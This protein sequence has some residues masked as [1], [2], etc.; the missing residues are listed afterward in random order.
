MLLKCPECELPVSDKAFNCPH[1]GY[2]ISQPTNKSTKSSKRNS[3]KRKR[4][5][6]GFGQITEIK[7]KRLRKPFRASVTVGKTD[8]GRPICKLLKPDAYFETYNDAYAALLEY[9]RNP[10]DLDNDIS[11]KELYDKWSE[12]YFESLSSKSSM[13]T[14]TSAWAYCSSVYNMRAKDVRARHIKGCMEEGFVKTDKGEIKYASPNTKTKIKSLFNLM[15]DYAIEYE[16][17]T[18]NYARSFIISNNVLKDVEN[19]KAHHIPFSAEEMDY[20]WNNRYNIPYVDV[21]IIQCYTGLRPQELGLI[22]LSNVNLNK[23]IMIGGMKTIAGTDRTI[24]IHP[25]I[26]DLVKYKYEEA[27]S[28]NSKYLI[29]CVDSKTYRDSKMFTYD[30]YRVRFNNIVKKLD[31]NPD[32]RP[33][34]PRMHFV[35]MAKNSGMDEYALKYII[36]HAISDLTERVYTKRSDDWLIEEMKKIK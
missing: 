32:H 14:I 24:P 18:T 11:V 26:K 7:N 23:G 16:I 3:N 30:K 20:L 4:L 31:L 6:N 9:N 15:Y 33:H 10:Y 17:V 25:K 8:E 27:I 5:P 28:M 34:D 35:T 12:Y 22:E 13:R 29:N 1:C 2:P 21:V 19:A 36:G